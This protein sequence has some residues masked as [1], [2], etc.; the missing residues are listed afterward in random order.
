MLKSL[1]KLLPKLKF[2]FKKSSPKLLESIDIIQDL[3]IE[4]VRMV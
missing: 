2:N 3:T 4:T 1:L